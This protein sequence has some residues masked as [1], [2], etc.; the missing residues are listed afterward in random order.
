MSGADPIIETE[1]LGHHYG[2][3]MALRG[4]D[5]TVHSGE[6]FGFLGHNGAGKTTTINVL[7]TLITPTSG[8]ARVCGFD[9]VAER[10]QV[11]RVIGY[12]PENVRLYDNL[13]AKENLRFFGQLSGVENTL[14]AIDEALGFLECRE[15]AGRRV[16]TFHKGMR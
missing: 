9:V 15:L 10:L 8:T 16:G 5:L 4:I 14:Q 6:V 7:T 13:T 12:L 11:Q 3:A 1:R 2:D